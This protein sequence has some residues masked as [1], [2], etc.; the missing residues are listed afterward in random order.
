MIVGSEI[1][2][3]VKV[4]TVVFPVVNELV[5]RVLEGVVDFEEIDGL[6][7]GVVKLEKIDELLNGVIDFDEVTALLR[8]VVDR[9]KEEMLNGVVNNDEVDK[10]IVELFVLVKELFETTGVLL[11]GGG[12]LIDE[13]VELG[14]VVPLLLEKMGVLLI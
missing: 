2:N 14:G 7:V 1:V 10:L 13:V 8:G 5:M 6:L 12:M 3:V 11:I 9:V 4:V